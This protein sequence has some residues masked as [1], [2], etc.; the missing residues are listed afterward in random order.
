MEKEQPHLR[1]SLSPQYFIINKSEP[2]YDLLKK[3][4]IDRPH[5]TIGNSHYFIRSAQENCCVC[6]IKPGN[7]TLLFY[8]ILNHIR[9]G[10]PDEEIRHAALDPA[11]A[12]TL[13][14]YFHITDSIEERLRACNGTGA[15]QQGAKC[16]HRTAA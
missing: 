11:N 15:E 13:P 16:V 7:G 5:H 8:E 4:L 14:E 12:T 6:R 10:I 1:T 2:Q 3:Q 9:E